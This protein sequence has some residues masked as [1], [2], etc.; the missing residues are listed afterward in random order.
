[1]WTALALLIVNMMNAKRWESALAVALIFA[2]LLSSGIGL[3]PNPYMPPIVRQSHFYELLSSMLLFGAIAGWTL[4]RKKEQ[5]GQTQ[6]INAAR[7]PDIS[8]E[9]R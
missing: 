6:T 2:G 1:M 5:R 3:F 7:N 8:I 9:T 4:H